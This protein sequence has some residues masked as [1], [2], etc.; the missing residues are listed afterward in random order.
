MS[1][2]FL[3]GVR[4]ALDCIVDASCSEN[5]CGDLAHDFEAPAVELFSSGSPQVSISGLSE[6]VVIS[7]SL[8]ASLSLSR[9]GSGS[10]LVSMF[11]GARRLG[12]RARP[13]VICVS[14][15]CFFG[16]PSSANFEV[17]PLG[18][19]PDEALPDPGGPRAR[20]PANAGFNRPTSLPPV[21]GLLGFDLG[22][23][24]ELD[25]ALLAGGFVADSNLG[26]LGDTV[27]SIDGGSIGGLPGLDDIAGL[28]TM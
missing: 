18:G 4:S 24:C 17:P 21:T 20:R 7:G 8:V 22:R 27:R 10:A 5:G 19:S 9:F 13:F 11:F 23:T 14:S 6:A 1:L 25:D 3:G 2:G 12:P 16:S 26:R 28:S 15:G